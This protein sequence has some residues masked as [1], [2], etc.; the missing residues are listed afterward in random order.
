MLQN[1]VVSAGGGGGTTKT[2]EMPWNSSKGLF[3]MTALPSM[4]SVYSLYLYEY[5][6]NAT[7]KLV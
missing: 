1:G 4:V 7:L 6:C 5:V 2:G 3:L